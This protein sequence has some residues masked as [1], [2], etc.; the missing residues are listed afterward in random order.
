MRND[1]LETSKFFAI[2]SVV[3]AHYISSQFII[4][5]PV[6]QRIGTFGVPLFLLLSGYFYNI[7]KYGFIKFFKNKFKTIIIPWFFTGSLV[8]I[9]S[10]KDYKLLELVEWGEWLLGI[11][12]YLYYLTIL[13][14]LF[15]LFSLKFIKNKYILMLL[16]TVNLISLYITNQNEYNIYSYLNIFNWIGFFSIGIL[17]KNKMNQLFE[18]IKN[19]RNLLLLSSVVIV[20]TIVISFEINYSGYFSEFSFLLEIIGILI[21][22]TLS[23]YEIFNNKLIKLVAKYS[24]SIYLLHFLFFPI[25]RIL[26]H[27]EVFEVVGP[28]LIITFCTLFIYLFDKLLSKLKIGQN[29]FRMLIGIR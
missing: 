4:I 28:L 5:S 6:L 24:F 15:L 21:I 25:K 8:Y 13:V 3:I 20:L 11:G 23:T 26:P 17:L 12:T 14:L 2:I 18:F 27:N 29:I 22:F 7:E 19:N 16:V 1:S 10:K 9:I